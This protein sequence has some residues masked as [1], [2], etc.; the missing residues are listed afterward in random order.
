MAMLTHPHQGAT[1]GLILRLVGTTGR[2]PG[3]TGRQAPALW[4]AVLQRVQGLSQ[5]RPVWT[6]SSAGAVCLWP[7][8]G[9]QLTGAQETP[10]VS[11]PPVF[12][13]CLLLVWV[14]CLSM[15]PFPGC[16]ASAVMSVDN[17]YILA[18][19]PLAAWAEDCG[20]F[21][22]QDTW[23]CVQAIRAIPTR[24]QL[25]GPG[26][27]SKSRAIMRRPGAPAT[28]D[29]RWR[30]PCMDCAQPRYSHTPGSCPQQDGSCTSNSAKTACLRKSAEM[31]VSSALRQC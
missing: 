4:Q 27:F 21:C 9:R 31:N 13:V 5:R 24:L 20:L 26:N 10:Q 25:G 19:S 16:P 7:A 6:L 18:Y 23:S 12:Q 15:Q 17:N 22:S 2:H 8:R 1:L 14:A 29:F 3:P 11:S 30:H 28:S